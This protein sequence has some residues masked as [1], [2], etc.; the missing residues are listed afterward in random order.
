MAATG[1]RDFIFYDVEILRRKLLF[2]NNFFEYYF[3]EQKNPSMT[4]VHIIDNANHF[5]P[6][7]HESFIK[8][9]MNQFIEKR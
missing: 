9:T 5:I 3:I 2:P 1:L 4:T 7:Q 8:Q 6:W